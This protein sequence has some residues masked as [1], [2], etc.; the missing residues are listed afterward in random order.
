M[1][2]CTVRPSIILAA[3]VIAAPVFICP[4]ADAAW[5]PHAVATAGASDAFSLGLD[6]AFTNPAL[7][8][9]STTAA[10]QLRVVGLGAGITN[11]GFGWHDYRTYNGATLSESDK[12][13][14]LARIP[15][16]GI[17]LSANAGATALAI[18]SGRFGVRVDGSGYGGG[19]LNRD[20][21]ELFL[22]GN[23]HQSD[24]SFDDSD[25]EGLATWNVRVSYG[26]PVIHLFGRSLLAG[27]RLSYVRGLYY[28]RAVEAR[29][30]L[31]TTAV[32]LTGNATGDVYTAEGGNGIG[33]DVGLAMEFGP[34][35]VAGLSV[36][37]L[38]HTVRWSHN[39]EVTHYTLE[40]EDLTLDN[41]EDSLWI[42]EDSRESLRG[43]T[44]GLPAR[45]ALT[46][47]HASSTWRVGSSVS[48]DADDRLSYSTIPMISVGVEH[49][50]LAFLPIR[51]G[52]SIGGA[53]GPSFG[54]GGGLRLWRTELNVGFR[55][56][57][58]IWLGHGRGLTAALALDLSL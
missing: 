33:L 28:G 21:V 17:H 46:L 18:R 7:L 41:F 23:A 6:A 48:I 50:V 44:R 22:F 31:R 58:G 12:A 47:A 32:G 9:R 51:M 52:A 29:A 45:F 10:T 35:W 25:A 56:D 16:S 36:Y 8:G 5:T 53:T 19:R 43:F 38:V 30:D 2:L 42:A 55:I 13:D 54:W 57:R 24:W 3:L 11:N 39:A 37:N 14:L 4:T 26:R 15:S 20:A 40:F 34:R 1:I 27:A 49:D